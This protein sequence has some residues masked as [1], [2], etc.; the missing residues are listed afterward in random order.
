MAILPPHPKCHNFP[1]VV[2]LFIEVC[3]VLDSDCVR[4]EKRGSYVVINEELD[5]ININQLVELHVF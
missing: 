3:V 2:D 4:L 5:R 1:V